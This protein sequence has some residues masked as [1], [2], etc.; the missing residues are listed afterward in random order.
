MN[1]AEVIGDPIGQSKSPIIHKYWLQQLGIEGDY[2]RT[3]V[4]AKELANFLTRRRTDPDWR[5]CNVTI[6]HKQAVIALLDRIEPEAFAMGAVNCVV[7]EKGGLAGYNTDIDGVGAALDTSELEG[8]KVAVIGAGGG[9][10]AVIAY[11]AKRKAKIVVVARDP[12]KAGELRKLAPLDVL[13]FDSADEAFASAAAIVNAS[14]LGMTGS[15]PVPR[16]LLEAVR[17]NSAGAMLFDLVT[18]PA[19]TEFLLCGERT[20]N[21]LVMLIGQARRAFELFFGS[22]PPQRD[23][24][25]RHLITGGNQ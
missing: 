15:D 1:F 11:L 13:P 3:H 25:L 22:S 21:G 17:Q 19:E 23:E 2:T 24:Q 18:T 8:E 6:P 4:E 10:R 16:P 14:S 12:D 5:G 9:A 20:V 7:P